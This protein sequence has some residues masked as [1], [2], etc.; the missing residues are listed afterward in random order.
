MPPRETSGER[1]H[2]GIPVSPG[3][4]HGRVFVIGK[5]GHEIPN[6]TLTDA[7]LEPELARFHA[8]LA[9]T[10]R[11]LEQV[12]ERV[13][14]VMGASEAGLFD[15]HLLVLEDPTLLAE[16]TRHVRHDRRNVESVLYQVAEQYACALSAV[17]DEYLRERAADVRDVASRV[18][19]HLMGTHGESDLANLSE[20]CLVIAHDLSPSTT[21]QLDRKRVLGFATE[22]GGQTSH[23]AILARKLQIPAAVGIPDITSRI[24][25]GEPA[26]LDGH[27]GSLVVNPSDQTLFEYGQITRRRVALEDTLQDL[28]TQPAITL[29]GHR[30]V[31]SA[32]IDHPD[33]TTPANG[34]GAEGV[35]LFRSEFLFLNRGELPDEEEQFRVYRAVAEA[36]APHAAII[37]TLDLGGDKMPTEMRH[38]GE[39]NPFLGWRAIRISLAEKPLFKTQLRAILRASAHGTVRVMYPMISS[40][41][42]LRTANSILR[43]THAE[44]KQAGVPV[45]DSVEVGAMIEIP[46]AALVA[47]ALASEVQFFSLGT[48]DLTGYTLA[49]D[50]L[51][52]RVAHLFCPWHPGVLRLI[53]MTVAAGKRHNRWTGVCGEMAGDINTIPLLL[54]LGVDELSA[55]PAV[56]PQA[57][58]LIRRV[59]LN[60]AQALAETA[61]ACSTAGEV[62]SLSRQF[63][64]RVAPALFGIEGA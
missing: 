38:P 50:R 27:A 49:V 26:L 62:L 60:E 55:T 9:A 54:G 47:D 57:K 29:D 5:R 7:E 11:D 10:R 40:V 63:A 52:E 35:G 32:N 25:P 34:N 18:M 39:A 28:R 48:N 59:R 17:E 41:D 56:L 24:R 2:Q 13:R 30:I 51:N 31:L 1:I 23:T 46:G 36:C 19:D 42:E 16:V 45:A 12:Q 4:A 21:A 3:I 15:A 22:A 53:Q 20:P 14:S 6:R 8:A 33:D 64:H 43:E 44:L 37:R 58:Y 61:L